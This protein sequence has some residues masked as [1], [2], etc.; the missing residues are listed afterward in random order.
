MNTNSNAG[1]IA[2]LIQAAC[3][4]LGFAMLATVMNPGDTQ[5]WSQVQKLAFILDRQALFQSWNI[6]IYVVFGVA[7]VVLSVTLHQLLEEGSIRLMSIATP[8]GLIWA[9]LVIASGMVASVG[10][11]AMADMFTRSPE[12]AAAAWLVIGVIQDGLGGGVEVVGGI[13]VLLV[14]IA[15]LRSSVLP[16]AINWLGI[17]VGVAGIATVVPALTVLGAVFG[18]SQIIWFVAVGIALLRH[19]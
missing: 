7:L 3:Y 5:G 16:A 19:G 2:A 9:G 10:V 14:S 12:Q 17:V 15:A 4:L 8:F 18:L 6:L 1:G 11:S 13:W